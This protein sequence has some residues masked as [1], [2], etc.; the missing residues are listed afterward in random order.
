MTALDTLTPGRSYD[1][2]VR[3]VSAAGTGAYSNSNKQDLN[4]GKECVA[5]YMCCCT[6]DELLKDLQLHKWMLQCMVEAYTLDMHEIGN[7][8]IIA[9]MS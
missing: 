5:F 8:L 7:S 1:V 3:A 4:R 2:Q 9:P 6:G